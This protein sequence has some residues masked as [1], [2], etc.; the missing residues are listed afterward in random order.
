MVSYWETVWQS[1]LIN[2][3]SNAFFLLVLVGLSWLVVALFKRTPL[4]KFFGVYKYRK[5]TIYLSELKVQRGG[6]TGLDNLP[7]SFKAGAV[8]L[9]FGAKVASQP[10]FQ[11]RNS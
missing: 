1:V 9:V 10:A 8:V 4:L 5:M 7:R 11:G 6:S 2:V 3:L